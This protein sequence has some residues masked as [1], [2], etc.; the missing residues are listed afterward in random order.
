MTLLPSIS[1][2]LR[3]A[4][5]MVMS[6]NSDWNKMLLCSSGREIIHLPNYRINV[7]FGLIRL[8]YILSL[9]LATDD[10]QEN[11]QSRLAEA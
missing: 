7:L 4:L 6:T 8:T 11:F 3:L 9:P 2:V 1:F 10:Y 5:F